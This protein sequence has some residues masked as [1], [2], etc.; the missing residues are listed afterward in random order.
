MKKLL[1]TLL[2]VM[3]TLTMNA[4]QVSKQNA[5]QN[6]AKCVNRAGL[7]VAGFVL[8]PLAAATAET[9][10]ATTATTATITTKIT[11]IKKNINNCDSDICTPSFSFFSVTNSSVSFSAM[12]CKNLI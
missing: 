2:A 1:F 3:V 7:N 9:T 8:E 4:E 5:L 11:T 6:L 12:N 10:A